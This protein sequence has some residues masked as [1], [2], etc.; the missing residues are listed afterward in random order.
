MADGEFQG[1]ATVRSKALVLVEALSG[2][3]NKCLLRTLHPREINTKLNLYCMYVCMC[4]YVAVLSMSCSRNADV[5]PPTK[6]QRESF[7]GRLNALLEIRFLPR[8]FPAIHFRLKMYVL[9]IT[10]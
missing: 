5:P 7:G 1:V 6:F 9:Q 8:N 10:I 2:P 4:T 3:L